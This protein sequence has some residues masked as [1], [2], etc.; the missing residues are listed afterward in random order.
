MTFDLGQLNVQVYQKGVVLLFVTVHGTTQGTGSPSSRNMGPPVSEVGCRADGRMATT[1][2]NQSRGTSSV[3]TRAALPKE[4]LVSF[5]DLIR[6][7]VQ[8]TGS[9][10]E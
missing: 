8:N 2:S 9:P 10:I 4:V 7:G 5:S 1:Q 6:T 3:Q